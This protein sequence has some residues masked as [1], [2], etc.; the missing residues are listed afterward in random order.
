MKDQDRYTSNVGDG[1]IQIPKIL[2]TDSAYATLSPEAKLLYGLCKD[3]CSLSKSKGNQWIDKEGNVFCYFPQKEVMERLNCGSDKASELMKQLETVG[4]IK[5]IRQG[6]CKPHRVIVNSILRTNENERDGIPE[7]RNLEA[8]ISGGNNTEKKN[9]E[10]NNTYS[11]LLDKKAIKQEIKENIY[12]DVLIDEMDPDLLN[13]IVSL[14]V[15][16]I[17]SKSASVKIAGEHRDIEVVRQRFMNLNDMHIRYVNDRVKRETS[18]IYSTRGYLLMH[19]FHAEESMDLFY[20]SLVEHDYVQG[21]K[22]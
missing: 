2:F 7:M 16:T 1:F 8:G 15:D 13:L 5:R 10:V 14:I 19:L 12:F 11:S 22:M 20:R 17:C 4:L 9:S 18:V 21:G 6:L 3:R